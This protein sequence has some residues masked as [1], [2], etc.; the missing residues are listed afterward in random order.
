MKYNYYCILLSIIWLISERIGIYG[1]ISSC[2]VKTG[3]KLLCNMVESD[4]TSNRRISKAKNTYVMSHDIDILAKSGDVDAPSKAEEKLEKMLELYESGHLECKPNTKT[5]TNL[6][7]CYAKSKHENSGEKAEGVLKRMMELY[8]NGDMDVKPNVISFTSVIDAWSRKREPKRAERIL[9]L[10]MK[11]HDT[12]YSDIEPTSVSFDTVINAWA[13]SGSP[14][15]AEELLKKMDELSRAG[16]IN[17]EPGVYSFASV[18]KA[19]ARIGSKGSAKNA[20]TILD[21]MLL[22]KNIQPNNICFNEVIDAWSRIGDTQNSERILKQM[23]GL[24][25]NKNTNVC[26]DL[27]SYNT[28]LKAYTCSHSRGSVENAQLLFDRM[29]EQPTLNITIRSYNTLLNVYSNSGRLD[30]AEQLLKKMKSAKNQVKPDVI[31]FTTLMKC[32]AHSQVEKKA[33]KAFIVFKN[34]SK[35]NIMSY[36]TLLN[37]CAYSSFGDD[38]EK[39]KA[40]IL[41]LEIF[42]EMRN[43]R[44]VQPDS[45]TYCN[46]LRACSNLL[47]NEFSISKREK[48]AVL[49]FQECSK[50]GLVDES[51]L[52]ELKRAVSKPVLLRT[53]KGRNNQVRFKDGKILFENI[54]KAWRRKVISQKYSRQA[55]FKKLK[56]RGK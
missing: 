38:D 12:G 26:P 23:E 39:K 14:V 2:N 41:A 35:K 13:E 11:L 46:L 42:E 48:T 36:N 22:Q 40:L 20:Q 33:N 30:L 34:I 3:K 47:S 24:H 17:C 54:P 9:E 5:F 21:K 10:M 29:L 49:L 32:I 45:V 51:V 43:S 55:T 56:R 53:M 37:A 25:K 8:K 4:T 19:W 6:I 27:V 18:I 31:T 52:K 16:S 28:V 1:F 7:N 50:Q 44:I 15:K